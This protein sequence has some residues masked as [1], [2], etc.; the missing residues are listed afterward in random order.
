MSGRADKTFTYTLNSTNGTDSAGTLLIRE[1]D[2]L[3]KVSVVATTD[4]SGTVI[5][6]A[7][8]GGV[9]STTVTVTK[10]IAVSIIANDGNVLNNI[11]IVAPA[12]CTLLI[13]G[14]G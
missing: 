14:Q 13:V 3:Q 10:T 8:A 12:G 6:D 2:G 4:T 7:S 11:R 5:G 9:A 1:G